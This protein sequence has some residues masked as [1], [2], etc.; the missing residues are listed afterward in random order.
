MKI[1]QIAFE[2]FDAKMVDHR[3]N[4]MVNGYFTLDTKKK[5]QGRQ[6]RKLND[7]AEDYTKELKKLEWTLYTNI[8]INAFSYW[9]F[10]VIFFFL[11]SVTDLLLALSY[12][13]I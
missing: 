1:L 10:F 11:L 6:K 12:S 7:L 8:Q 4:N 3:K 2:I 5:R 9:Y 13:Y